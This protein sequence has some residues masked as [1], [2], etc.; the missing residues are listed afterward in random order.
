MFCP[1]CGAPVNEEHE[2]CPKCGTKLD[3]SDG[4]FTPANART[5]QAVSPVSHDA[6]QKPRTGLVIAACLLVAALA[7]GGVAAFFS[8][9]GSQPAATQDDGVAGVSQ[10][11]V[12][13]SSEDGQAEADASTSTEASYFCEADDYVVICPDDVAARLDSHYSYGNTYIMCDGVEVAII[14]SES[15][16]VDGSGTEHRNRSYG[17]SAADDASATVC[18]KCRLLYINAEGK[19]VHWGDESGTILAVE[20]LVGIPA[21]EFLGYIKVM[22][23]GSYRDCS[24]SLLSDDNDTSASSTPAASS[25]TQPAPFW[26]V[27]V[28]AFKTEGEAQ[29]YA[30]E[31]AAKGFS[32]EVYLTTDWSNLNSEPWYVITVGSFATE[33][34]AYAVVGSAQSSGQPDAYVKYSGDYIG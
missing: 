14:S 26:G 13:S 23:D 17:L 1:E 11:Q 9:R 15:V 21:E 25:T 33:G 29:A 4:T 28:G 10:T 32:A 27:W 34:E 16:H 7:G 30:N 8:L 24:Y 22:Y 3:M 5:Q 19:N 12:I 31:W 20:E 18:V 6:P 2:F